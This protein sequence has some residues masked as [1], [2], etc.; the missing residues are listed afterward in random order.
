MKKTKCNAD[1]SNCLCKQNANGN[2]FKKG[3]KVYLADVPRNRNDYPHSTKTKYVYTLD[4]VNGDVCWINGLNTA[5][6]LTRCG[7]FNYCELV[8]ADDVPEEIT[9]ED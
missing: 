8:L 1:H 4:S 9:D 7:A 3:D 2:P 5:H 6:N